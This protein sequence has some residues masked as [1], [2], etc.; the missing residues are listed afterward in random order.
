MPDEP[1]LPDEALCEPPELP[2]PLPP[3]AL[4]EP[5]ELL[6]LDALRESPCELPELLPLDAFCEPPELLPPE[7]FREPPDEPLFPDEPLLPD[8]PEL[9]LMPPR[10]LPL[11]ELPLCPSPCA[12]LERSRPELADEPLMPSLLLDEPDAFWLRSAMVLVLRIPVDVHRSRT[13]GSPRARRLPTE[14][15]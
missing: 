9:A 12:E 7:A 6:P 1:E 14:G 2:E 4:C 15:A 11:D 5:P 8:E 3:D 13:R 10:E